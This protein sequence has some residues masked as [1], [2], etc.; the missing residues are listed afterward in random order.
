[1]LY[2]VLQALL[3]HFTYCSCIQNGIHKPGNYATEREFGEV[4]YNNAPSCIRYW[5][6]HAL[7]ADHANA[8]D[9]ADVTLSAPLNKEG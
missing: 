1:M 6:V 5:C 7:F 3:H 8:M 9:E 4:L 2:R